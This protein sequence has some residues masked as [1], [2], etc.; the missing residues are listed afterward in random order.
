MVE[1]GQTGPSAAASRQ[2][3]GAD[4]AMHQEN[5]ELILVET[6]KV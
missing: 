6:R 1:Y 2:I 3:S 5:P 4:A